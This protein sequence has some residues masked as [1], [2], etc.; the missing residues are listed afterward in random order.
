MGFLK[1]GDPQNHWFQYSS[2]VFLDDLWVSPFLGNLHISYIILGL[3]TGNTSNSGKA[4]FPVLIQDWLNFPCWVSNQHVC[5][6]CWWRPSKIIQNPP[7]LAD[8]I[9]HP[10]PCLGV[11]TIKTIKP[12]IFCSDEHPWISYERGF[13][14]RFHG[15]WNVLNGFDR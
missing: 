1:M 8:L 6:V 10:F 13:K 3:Y 9:P 4:V 5:C 15:Y 11:K 2:C 14:R 12:S 7:L